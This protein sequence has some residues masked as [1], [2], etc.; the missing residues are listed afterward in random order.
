MTDRTEGLLTVPQAAAM[1]G[2]TYQATH[3]LVQ[4]R[5]L[6]VVQIGTK[7]YVPV[8][9]IADRIRAR[10]LREVVRINP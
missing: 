4:R 7:K 9:E 6:D 2:A 8:R 5:R 1:L 3:R 10:Q